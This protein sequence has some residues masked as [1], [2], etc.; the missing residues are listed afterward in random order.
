ML[1]RNWT[2]LIRHSETTKMRRIFQLGKNCGSTELCGTRSFSLQQLS[3]RLQ[4]QSRFLSAAAS[5]HLLQHRVNVKQEPRGPS[6]FGRRCSTP[7]RSFLSVSNIMRDPEHLEVLSPEQIE[8]LRKRFPR[9]WAV[10]QSVDHRCQGI[11]DEHDV[12]RMC[13]DLMV[14]EMTDFLLEVLDRD[15]DGLVDFGEWVQNYK[16]VT[17]VRNAARFRS[18]RHTFGIGVAGN[19]AGH[20]DQAGEGP[21]DA[22]LGSKQTMPPAIF[23]FYVPPGKDMRTNT[24]KGQRSTASRVKLMEMRKKTQAMMRGLT[25]GTS[26]SSRGYSGGQLEDQDD[27]GIGQK[28]LVEE[29]QTQAFNTRG[30]SSAYHDSMDSLA[31]VRSNT[32]RDETLEEKLHR[33]RRFPIA[34]AIIH[35]PGK[36]TGVSKVQ[37][38]PEVALYATIV[39]ETPSSGKKRV[40]KLIPERLAAFND[41]SVRSLEGSVKLSEK[42]NWGRA[43]KGISIRHF[44]IDCFDPKTPEN[45]PSLVSRLWIG[46]WVMRNGVLQEYTERDWIVDRMN[47]QVPAENDPA[48]KWENVHE[49]LAASNY[50]DKTWIA[51]GAGAYTPWGESNFLNLGDQSAVLIWDE[52]KWPEGPPPKVL[53]DIFRD[54]EQTPDGIIALHQTFV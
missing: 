35:H 27:I 11:L 48:D 5:P 28:D 51:L 1:H 17:L 30:S 15:G 9:Q 20:L 45:K 22:V 18:W 33:L 36:V 2:L 10:F 8:E 29:H 23:A 12:H 42:K 16:T 4:T 38:E 34:S 41:C 54:S 24:L 50:P 49:L 21:G 25:G 19:V 14:P 52:K 13:Q 46:S 6:I 7:S 31:L 26:A 40:K 43:S 47:N 44:N 53:E 32:G 39:Y 3:A 37:V